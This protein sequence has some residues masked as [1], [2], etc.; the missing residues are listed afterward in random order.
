ME[1]KH[2]KLC[3]IIQH[4]L[5]IMLAV[6]AIFKTLLKNPYPS[7]NY[8]MHHQYSSNKKVEKKVTNLLKIQQIQQ[9]NKKSL[10]ILLLNQQQDM[11]NI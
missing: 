1:F 8:K 11:V 2:Y 3:K 5:I 9:F 4:K 7:L 10:L 6:V